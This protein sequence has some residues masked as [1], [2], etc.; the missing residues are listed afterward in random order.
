MA[1]KTTSTI[2][3]TGRRSP[4]GGGGGLPFFI[5][6]RYLFA[7]K[8]H[9]VINIISM[10]SVVG[11]V[12]GTAAL[13]VVISV[14][15]GFEDLAKSMYHTFDAD[16]RITPATGKVFVPHSAAFEEV[17]RLPGVASFSEVLEENVLLEHGGYQD[18]ATF[19]GI[20]SAFLT[21]TRM[22]QAMLDSMPFAPWHGELEQAIVG[23]GVQYRL[24]INVYLQWNNILTVY[25]PRRG[26]PLSLANPQASL[27]SATIIPAGVFAIEQSYDNNYVFVPIRFVRNLFDY[28]DEVSA[29][30]LQLDSTANATKIQRQITKLLGDGFVVQSRY[31]QHE[32]MFRM[33][34]SEKAAVYAI[35]LFM[36]IVISGN[37]LGSLTM[38]IIEKQDDVFTLRSMGANDKLIDRIF[39]FEGWMISLLGVIAGI[40]IGLLLC[41]A[42]QTFGIIRMEG[43]FLVNAYP[44]SVHFADVALIA[45]VVAAIGYVAAWLPVRYLKHEKN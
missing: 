1:N 4:F 30:E 13:V 26:V 18:I 10:I 38:L 42:Q 44:V 29:I 8:S 39:L 14:F 31:E 43:N 37:V 36:L 15:N 16:L 3:G 5:A 25:A 22:S 21:T 17:R 9:N 45:A 28:T 33:M 41:F 23:R 27:N 35:L 32:T 2:K 6:R 11:V 40:V 7:K 20:D 12:I 24:G 34:K 19:K